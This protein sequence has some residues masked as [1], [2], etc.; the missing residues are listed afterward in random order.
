MTSRPVR[1][2]AGILLAISLLTGSV[3]GMARGEPSIGLIAGLG[4]GVVL[5]ALAARRR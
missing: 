5:A 3:I 4:V 1:S 2:A